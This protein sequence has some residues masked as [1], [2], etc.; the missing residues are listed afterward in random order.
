MNPVRNSS[1]Q[2]NPAGIIMEPNPAGEQRDV[3]S[4]GVKVSP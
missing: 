4:N 2:S 1:G 3:I